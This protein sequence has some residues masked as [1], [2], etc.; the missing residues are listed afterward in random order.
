MIDLFNVTATVNVA[1]IID[2]VAAVTGAAYSTRN[3]RAARQGVC[4]WIADGRNGAVLISARTSVRHE[5]MR[6]VIQLCFIGLASMSF[7]FGGPVTPLALTAQLLSLVAICLVAA[8]SVSS[9]YS[10]KA[11]EE[12]VSKPWDGRE[13]RHSGG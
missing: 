2:L 9:W 10:R 4:D 1:E 5:W 3:L 13:R 12:E 11:I 6:I 7:L 8:M